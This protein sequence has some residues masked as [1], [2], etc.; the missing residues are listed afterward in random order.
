MSHFVSSNLNWVIFSEFDSHFAAT[1]FVL[2]IGAA[3][4]STEFTGLELV[5]FEY[6][7]FVTVNILGRSPFIAHS[8]PSDS[9]RGLRL[10]Q[11]AACLVQFAAFARLFGQLFPIYWD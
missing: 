8:P 2:L 4:R 10:V 11:F 1:W 5:I 7:P 9:L 3:N 6:T